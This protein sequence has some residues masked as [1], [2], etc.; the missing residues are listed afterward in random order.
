M[1]RQRLQAV[2][3]D[4]KRRS[5]TEAGMEAWYPYYAGYTEEFAAQVIE[6][7]NLGPKSTVLDPWNGCGTTTRVADVQGH[8]A[9]GIDINPVATLVASAKL[10]RAQD[11]IHVTG[12]AGRLAAHSLS[13]PATLTS[14]DPLRKWLCPALT[15]TYRSIEQGILADLAVRDGAVLSPSA[16][17]LPPLAAFL[18]L[19]LQR[20]ARHFAG[21]KTTSNPTW[22]RPKTH[23][24]RHDAEALTGVWLET[25]R[26]MAMDLEAAE[27]DAH[28]TGS[29]V[30]LGD[31]RNLPLGDSAVDLV[32]TSP[33]YCTRIDYVVSTS[34]E[35]AALGIGDKQ[36]SFD[37][38]RRTSMGT[39]LA[40][41]A[42]APAAETFPDEVA[43]V[44]TRIREHPSKASSSYYYKTY[45]QYF[46]DSMASVAELR[47]V[48]K[49]GAAAVL[50]VQSSYYKDI[51]VDLPE[52]YVAMGQALDMR[53]SIA[54]E[55]DVNRF[56]AQINSRST[57]H[58]KSTSHREAVVVLE[59]A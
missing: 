22:L 21:I 15:R 55:Y 26:A 11:A 14:G 23:A 24:P 13:A 45:A 49:P 59:A 6:A 37:E 5:G 38:L 48:L 33:P 29:Q 43:S 10:A 16:Q 42:A 28:R 41:R 56:L 46:S 31:A 20:A 57:A 50:V 1:L 32:V 35:L 52:L 34:F 39:P 9:I 12:L 8:T 27:A 30:F 53:A 44:L 40:R 47:R 36:P 2:D 54:A 3:I 58:R 4:A 51:Y 7:S 17:A 19:A 25:V 18:V